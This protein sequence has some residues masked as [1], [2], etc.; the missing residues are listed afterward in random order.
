MTDAER[1]RRYEELLPA[2]A[3]GALD[4]EER[5]ELEAHLAGCP[6]CR[7][8]L[9]EWAATAE[10]LAESVDP[11]R[12]AAAARERLLR[13]VEEQD[14]A[15]PGPAERR[16][17]GPRFAAGAAAAAVVA[18]L[19]AGLLAGGTWASLRAER[20]LAE[21]RTEVEALEARLADSRRV[22]QETRLELAALTELAAIL[23]TAPPGREVVLAGLEPAPGGQGRLYVDPGRG[24]GVLVAGNLPALPE[25]RVYQLWTITGGVPRSAGVFRP[26]AAGAALHRIEELPEGP[27]EAWA[28]TVEPEGGVPQPTGEMVLLG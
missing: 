28:V 15:R 27:V 20:E 7:A 10:A 18:A 9:A 17:R 21:R 14:A 24:R 26:A 23:A 12:P 13:R 22:V 4:P 2:H 16:R 3:L 5:R 6:E 8:R 25:D 11:A 1:H 19:L